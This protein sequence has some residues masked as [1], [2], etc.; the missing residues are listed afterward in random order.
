MC[1]VLGIATLLTLPAAAQKGPLTYKRDKIG[2]FNLGFMM[3]LNYN[4]YRVEDN[5]QQQPNGQ[6]VYIRMQPQMGLTLGMVSN[7]NVTDFLS[8][9]VVPHFTF[10]QRN[11]EYYIPGQAKPQLRSIETSYFNVPL[12]AQ[13]RTTYYKGYRIYALSGVQMGFNMISSKR[14]NNDPLLIK[15]KTQDVAAVIGVGTILYGD[16]VKLSPEL[17]YSA[18]LSNLYIPKNTSYAGVLNGLFSQTL[19]LSFNFE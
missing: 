6:A 2:N 12:L 8:V 13:W 1:L 9:R 11:F 17:R 15:L 10:E 4:R 14:V 5:F 3:G 7:I 18:G 19:T 16:R